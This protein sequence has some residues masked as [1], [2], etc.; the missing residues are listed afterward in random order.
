MPPSLAAVRRTL[1]VVSRLAETRYLRVYEV[2][3]S[4]GISRPAAHRLLA[5]LVATGY[6]V[7]DEHGP[8]YL[9][10]PALLAIS[11]ATGFGDALRDRARVALR[12]LRDEV[13]ETLHVA[14]RQGS[15]MRLIEG[16]RGTIEPAGALRVGLLLPAHTTAA[17]KAALA[18]LSESE[19][20]ALH[21][22]GLLHIT[23]RSLATIDDLLVD[24][25][26]VRSRGYALNV[27]EAQVG[28]SGIAAA[29]PHGVESGIVS[30]V[31]TAPT[32]RL[33]AERI[34]HIVPR[35]RRAAEILGSEV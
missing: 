6:A 17:G 10:G 8:G 5:T 19:V 29:A 24:L 11:R 3:Q 26:R 13:D 33:N 28:I 30:I 16:V 14:I 21:P 18:N 35:L 27:E 12:M 22:R 20:R 1:A 4:Q 31:V 9:P 2:A 34:G 25:G 32:E 7:R 15:G 23:P